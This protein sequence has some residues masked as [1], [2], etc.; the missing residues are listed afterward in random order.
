MNI[1]V[2]PAVLT[3]L[4]TRYLLGPCCL[5]F[6]DGNRCVNAIMKVVASPQLEELC[7][8]ADALEHR[9]T[10]DFKRDQVCSEVNALFRLEGS[11][12]TPEVL[13]WSNR[14]P[15]ATS[16]GERFIATEDVGR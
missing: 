9:D 8:E 10:D 11:D 3:P 5:P 16:P 1:H 14:A 6:Q 13:G 15:T 4:L 2:A 12:G 7:S